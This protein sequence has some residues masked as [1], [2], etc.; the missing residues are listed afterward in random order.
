MEDFCLLPCSLF[1]ACTLCC[2]RNSD[3]WTG[4]LRNILYFQRRSWSRFVDNPETLRKNVTVKHW[5]CPCRILLCT[6]LWW[7]NW[8]TAHQGRCPL[9]GLVRLGDFSEVGWIG[10]TPKS[11]RRINFWDKHATC[12]LNIRKKK[13]KNLSTWESF[14]GVCF[15][16]IT[17]LV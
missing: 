16:V 7:L 17:M 9:Q 15:S 2:G 1:R 12:I 6:C 14:V 3:K 13:S 4:L 11:M 8:S 10:P 5:F